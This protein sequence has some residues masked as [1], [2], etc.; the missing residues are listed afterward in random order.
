[1]A[2]HVIDSG[3]DKAKAT[4]KIEG[5]VTS[6][7]WNALREFC[8][9]ALKTKDTVVL[10]L[11]EVCQYDFSLTVFVCLLRRTVLPLGKQLTITGRREEFVCLYSRGE[12]CSIIEASTGCRCRNLF[13]RSAG[14]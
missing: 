2:I 12:H 6:T 13:D 11:E 14:A 3:K 1:M 4:I 9:D 8:L 7:D 5:I 10:D